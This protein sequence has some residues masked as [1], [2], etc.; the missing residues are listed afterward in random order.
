MASKG[1]AYDRGYR[2]GI[3]KG[4][5]EYRNPFEPG[6]LADQYKKGFDAARRQRGELDRKALN[7]KRRGLI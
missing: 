4:P 3:K 6:Y 5:V 2:D 1:I 7:A